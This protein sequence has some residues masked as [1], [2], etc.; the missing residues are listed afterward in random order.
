MWIVCNQEDEIRDILPDAKSALLSL[1]SYKKWGRAPE[2]FGW[3]A[4]EYN[5]NHAQDS[6]RGETYTSFK[7][8]TDVMFKL[9]EDRHGEYHP[10]KITRKDENVVKDYPKDFEHKDTLPNYLKRFFFIYLVEGGPRKGDDYGYMPWDDQEINE[11]TEAINS[12]EVDFI[13]IHDNMIRRVEGKDY[14]NELVV[15]YFQEHIA[16][17]KKIKE[18]YLRTVV[19]KRK[20]LDWKHFE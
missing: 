1:T 9:E 10:V 19:E 4:C 18:Q 13:E 7:G 16:E 14:P 15:Q 12:G 3:Y 11:L 17:D 20:H 6:Y 8:K 5:P 2:E